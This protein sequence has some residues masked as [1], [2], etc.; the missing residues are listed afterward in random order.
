MMRSMLFQANLPY[1]FWTHALAAACHIKNILPHS[2]ANNKTPFELFHS[3]LPRYTHL[4]PFGCNVYAHIPPER[5]EEQSKLPLVS[6]RGF[7][8]GY[9]EDS[10]SYKYYDLDCKRI[11]VTRNIH[12]VEC[13]FPSKNDFPAEQPASAVSTLPPEPTEQ[14]EIFDSITVE[15]PSHMAMHAVSTDQNDPTSHEEAIQCSDRDK[16][17]QAMKDELRSIDA[18]NTWVLCRLPPGRMCIGSRWVFKLK[19][20]G[21]NRIIIIIIIIDS[22]YPRISARASS[23]LSVSCVCSLFL[24]GLSGFH[25][26]Y[27]PYLL[28]HFISSLPVSLMYSN[29]CLMVFGSPSNVSIRIFSLP[30]SLLNFFL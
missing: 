4:A 19:K 29:V 30:A 7:L 5:H 14:R 10:A 17:L 16:W 22:H 6:T 12:I 28:H 20:D 27:Y 1:R 23:C 13:E 9:V 11:D 8:I 18:D 26:L 15:P 21:N 24:S 2:S 3:K 25:P